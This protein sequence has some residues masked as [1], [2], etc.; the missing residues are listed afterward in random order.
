MSLAF[1]GSSTDPLPWN[2]VKN[3]QRST[4][5]S[6]VDYFYKVSG[7]LG[8]KVRLVTAL[9]SL[10]RVGLK[11]TVSYGESEGDL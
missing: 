7:Y 11:A 3:S 8:L 2:Y 9:K 5:F 1:L 6:Y 4:P 10:D